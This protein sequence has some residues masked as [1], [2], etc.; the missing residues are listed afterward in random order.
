MIYKTYDKQDNKVKSCRKKSKKNASP[1]KKASSPKRQAGKEIYMSIPYSDPDKMTK[2]KY[3]NL[4]PLIIITEQDCSVCD[5]VKELCE[6]NYIKYSVL[7]LSKDKKEK[8]QKFLN[9][10]FPLILDKNNE[11]ISSKDLENKIGRNITFNN[12]YKNNKMSDLKQPLTI[13]TD[14][15]CGACTEVKELCDKNNIKYNALE[16]KEQSDDKRKE[17]NKKT[18]NYRYV[19]VIFDNEQNFLGGLKEL[20]NIINKMKK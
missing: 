9:K 10:S 2:S 12:I 11:I 19:P 15:G 16:L 3:H 5:K 4:E 7:E 18:N 6:I 8:I 14:K 17:I 13:Y 1:K 20:K